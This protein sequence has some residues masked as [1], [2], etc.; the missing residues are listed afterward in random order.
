MK[1]QVESLQTQLASQ[2]LAREKSAL[3]GGPEFQQKLV[4]WIFVLAQ[5]DLSIVK[6]PASILSL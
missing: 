2:Q 6:A 1:A 3:F 4:D 5:N